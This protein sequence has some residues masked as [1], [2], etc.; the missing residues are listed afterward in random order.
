MTIRLDGSQIDQCIVLSKS[1]LSLFPT[2]SHQVLLR[3]NL[4]RQ[5]SAA[6]ES[7]HGYLFDAYAY[8]YFRT[9]LIRLKVPLP[10]GSTVLTVGGRNAIVEDIALHSVEFDWNR[11][12][13]G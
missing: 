6:P 11:E 12:L 1:L 8:G 13:G 3:G 10:D 9:L 5:G 7:I 2:V 4:N